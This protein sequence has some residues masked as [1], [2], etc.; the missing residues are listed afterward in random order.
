[1]AVDHL[2][3][4][5]C[6]RFARNGCRRPR[7][8]IRPTA[9]SRSARC[10]RRRAPIEFTA[11]ISFTR[12]PYKPAVR[13][14]DSRTPRPVRGITAPVISPDGTQVAFIALGDLWLMPIGGERAPTDQRSIR[15]DG[16]DLVARRPLDR[17]FIRS[18]RHA[19]ISG[20]A[21]CRAARTARSRRGD[22]GVVGAA[23]ERDRL[24][25][26]RRRAGDHRTRRRRSTADF[27]MPAGRPGRLK[28]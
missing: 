9:R 20:C 14:F 8:S 17:V 1:M 15:R 16:S 6:F 28:A 11:A 19:W 5:T 22:Q 25:Q 27:E 26:S 4:K 10:Q 12:T 2:A 24:H 18:R 23:R 13:D 3:T 7:S 21:T